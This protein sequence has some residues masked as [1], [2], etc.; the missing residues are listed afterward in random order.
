MNF[1][2]RNFEKFFNEIL[3]NFNEKFLNERL[4]YGIKIPYAIKR[5]SSKKELNLRPTDVF[6]TVCRTASVQFE[7]K[8]S[9]EIESRTPR[10]KISCSTN[11][12]YEG[13]IF[14]KIYFLIIFYFFNF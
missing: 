10:L 1:A 12:S 8:P 11:L 9:R 7:P 6:L 3:N 2:K 5:K 14:R 13:K 4:V